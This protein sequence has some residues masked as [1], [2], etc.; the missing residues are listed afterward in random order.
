MSTRHRFERSESAASFGKVFGCRRLGQAKATD[1]RCVECGPDSVHRCR[2]ACDK[3]LTI[4]CTSSRKASAA[5]DEGAIF[6][7]AR[8]S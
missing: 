2:A 4:D 5:S 6:C 8:L 7:S 3:S 1:M